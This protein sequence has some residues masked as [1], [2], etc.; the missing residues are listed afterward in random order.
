MYM[1][2]AKS[3][4]TDKCGIVCALGCVLGLVG[5]LICHH[6]NASH[7]CSARHRYIHVDGRQTQF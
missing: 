4:S 1:Y 6:S 2:V 3:L 7:S 5:V